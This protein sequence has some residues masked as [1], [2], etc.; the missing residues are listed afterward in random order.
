MILE[1][2]ENVMD[3]FFFAKSVELTL[4]YDNFHMKPYQQNEK[5]IK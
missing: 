2:Q 3:M 1:N 4:T 5:S